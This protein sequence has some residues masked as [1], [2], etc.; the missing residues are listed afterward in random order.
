VVEDLIATL[1]KLHVPEREKSD[2]LGILAPMKPAS[3]RILCR[4]KG[5]A[6]SPAHR[7]NPHIPT[8]SR[9][10]GKSI[11]SGGHSMPEEEVTWGRKN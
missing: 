9:R 5:P 4:G 7:E 3:N 6:A 2:L 1:D 11:R 8:H 10:R